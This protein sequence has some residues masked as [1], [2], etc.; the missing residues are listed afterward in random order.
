MD[1]QQESAAV[2]SWAK[3]PAMAAMAKVVK[4]LVK[5]A[6]KILKA[7]I[8]IWMVSQ[9]PMKIQLRAAVL[10][11]QELMVKTISHTL[12]PKWAAVLPNLESMVKM[13]SHT[14]T[15]K[16]AVALRN[17]E[18]MIK[19]ISHLPTLKWA[20]ALLNLESMIRKHMVIVAM[21]S[22]DWQQITALIARRQTNLICQKRRINQ[23]NQPER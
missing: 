15:P 13:I 20:V 7:A 6:V 17:L 11:N 21:L 18:S 5:S 8:K 10:L 2:M 12:I 4:E 3:K 16:W 1:R 9:V 19:A 14:L 22:Q 23:Q